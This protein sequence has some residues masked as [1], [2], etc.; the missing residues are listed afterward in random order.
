DSSS[1][2]LPVI[3]I[4]HLK[5]IQPD[6][7]F[8]NSTSK[9]T[10]EIKIN[11]T[12]NADGLVELKNVSA[13]SHE[14]SINEMDIHAN[15]LILHDGKNTLG[16]DSGEVRL[17]ITGTKL[18]ALNNQ[19]DWKALLNEGFIKNPLTLQLINDATINLETIKVNNLDLG[20]RNSNLLQYFRNSP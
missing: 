9:G 5:L 7:N 10:R 20:T 1:M 19:V 15:K 17:F 3:S 8:K 2:D 18:N 4:D 6:L 14:I 12:A 16:I 11:A 13:E